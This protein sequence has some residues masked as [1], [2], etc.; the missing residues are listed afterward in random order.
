MLALFALLALLFTAHNVV[1]RMTIRLMAM[2][3]SDVRPPVDQ[4][5]QFWLYIA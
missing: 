4:V 5:D 2:V 1:V 3:V